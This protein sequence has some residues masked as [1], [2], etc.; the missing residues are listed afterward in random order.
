MAKDKPLTKDELISE[1]AEFY[2]GHVEPGVQRIIKKEIGGVKKE[3]AG[4]KKE[5]RQGFTELK[6]E[7]VGN[8]RRIDDLKTDI[9]DTPS[10]KEFNAVKAKVERYHPT[11]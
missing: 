11:N 8:S 7:V 4:V 6:A 9:A 5:M 1:L 3:L 10:R 2:V